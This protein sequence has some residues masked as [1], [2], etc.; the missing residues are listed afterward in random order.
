MIESAQI[1]QPLFAVIVPLYN[2][3]NTVERTIRSVLAQT[4]QRFELIIVDDGGTDDSVELV[5]AFSDPRLRL[6]RQPNMGPGGARNRGVAESTAPFLAFLDADDNWRP[7]HL[8]RALAALEENPQVAAFVSSFDVGDYAQIYPN[9]IPML[10]NQSGV[11]TMP[12]DSTPEQV[13]L[14]VDASQTS[15]MVVRRSSFEKYGGFYEK[16]RCT[17]GEDT[18]MFAPMFICEPIYFSLHQEVDFHVEDSALGQAHAGAHPPHPSLVDPEPFK[19]LGASQPVLLAKYLAIQ[20]QIYTRRLA[21]FGRYRDIARLRKAFP[22]P[23][24]GANFIKERKVDLLCL[25]ASLGLRK[26][27]GKVP[28][29][30]WM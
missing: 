1:E 17:Y 6:I 23:P 9:K 7:R 2:K 15:C 12:Q 20:R 27:K 21:K 22:P 13:K 28:A 4:E 24:P 29:P 10:V 8:E 14:G 3:R 26:G 25:L 18:Y 5:E 16:N 19:K 30:L 11:W